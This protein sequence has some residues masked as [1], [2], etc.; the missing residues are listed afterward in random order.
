M[1]FFAIIDVEVVN[2]DQKKVKID[3]ILLY[4]YDYLRCELHNCNNGAA[5]AAFYRGWW[6]SPGSTMVLQMDIC[7]EYH[8]KPFYNIVVSIPI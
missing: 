6:Q 1:R 2:F 8:R 7:T 4:P 5:L 3:L